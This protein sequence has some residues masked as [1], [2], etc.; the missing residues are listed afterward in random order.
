MVMGWCCS[1]SGFLL[2]R[3]ITRCLVCALEVCSGD[4]RRCNRFTSLAGRWSR[5]VFP[6][7]VSALCNQS[8]SLRDALGLGVVCIWLGVFMDIELWM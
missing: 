7:A 3:I 2:Q 6:S 5:E 4:L 8:V 1:R